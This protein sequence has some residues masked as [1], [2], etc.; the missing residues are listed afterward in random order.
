MTE[1]QFALLIGLVAIVGIGLLLMGWMNQRAYQRSI[2]EYD[3]ATAA[4]A[5]A[6]VGLKAIA[7]DLEKSDEQ[8]EEDEH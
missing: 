1:E 3:K 6:T 4:M 7:L 5:K 2:R 8:G